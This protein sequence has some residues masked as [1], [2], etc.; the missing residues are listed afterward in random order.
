MKVYINKIAFVSVASLLLLVACGQK[1][2]SETEE[3]LEIQTVEE[4]TPAEEI[5]PAQKE[6]QAPVILPEQKQSL[7]PVKPS[8]S[9]TPVDS[10][11]SAQELMA[12]LKKWETNLKTFATDFNQTSSY[13]GVEINRSQGRLYYDFTRGLL[14]WEVLDSS[15]ELTQA[16]ISNKKE[17]VILDEAL[18]PVATLSWQE[19][20]KGQANQA[21]FDIGNY[22]Q[23]A[24]KHRVEVQ[25]QDATHAVLA[26][27]P[28]QA[29]ANYTLLI[30]LSKKDFFPQ[31]IAIQSDDML[32]TNQ[33]V[34]LR[35]NETL[36]T[37]LFGGFFK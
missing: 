25:T 14:R 1:A 37:D 6:E 35:K 2:P 33:L 26:F 28:T 19:W 16:A 15:G 8:L 32:T 34:S 21:L 13:D 5:L 22:A 18:H 27:M 7:R 4:I 17:I 29:D 12:Q 10:T 31:E 11:Y 3:N 36:A 9:T 30:T 24:D 23:L 20:Q